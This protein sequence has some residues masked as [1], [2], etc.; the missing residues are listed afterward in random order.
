MAY[1]DEFESPRSGFR[2]RPGSRVTQ[3]PPPTFAGT[4]EPEVPPMVHN[5]G[6]PGGTAGP[7]PEP[8]PSAPAPP[9][10]YNWDWISQGFDRGKLN[11]PNKHTFKYDYART[12]APFD[13]RRGFTSEVLNALNALGYADF[14]SPGGDKL[15]IRNVTQRGLQ[16]EMDPR[17]FFGD[18]IDAFDAQDPNATRWGFDAFTAPTPQ[19]AAYGPAPS[20][21]LLPPIYGGFAPPPQVPV[22][23]PAGSNMPPIFA[24][25]KFWQQLMAAM[26]PQYAPG[27]S[28]APRP[29][30]EGA[31]YG[32]SR[33]PVPQQNPQIQTLLSQLFA[34]LTAGG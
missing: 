24:D 4:Q 19:Q 32:T 18:F 30:F 29:S 11:D 20:P 1:I 8:P 10:S 33:Q 22:M 7:N 23:P 12:V 27:Y 31:Q 13:P 9:P 16:A 3:P 17:D 21:F 6:L 25:P 14:Y 5:A 15:G 26:Q 28:N 2:Q 34:G